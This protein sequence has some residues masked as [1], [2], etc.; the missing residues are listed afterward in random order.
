[1]H[2]ASAAAYESTSGGSIEDAAGMNAGFYQK[3]LTAGTELATQFS[4]RTL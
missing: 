4:K 1:M 3:G 2:G